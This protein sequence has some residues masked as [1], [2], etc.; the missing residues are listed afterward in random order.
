MKIYHF[1]EVLIQNL[2]KFFD[3][4]E[5]ENIDETVGNKLSSIVRLAAVFRLDIPPEFI[6]LKDAVKQM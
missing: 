2:H 3:V 4:E 6:E 1:S 5:F